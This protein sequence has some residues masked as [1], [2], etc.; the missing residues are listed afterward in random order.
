M[1][2]S[3]AAALSDGVMHNTTVL[4]ENHTLGV[5]D[6]AGSQFFCFEQS[7]IVATDKILTF[8]AF[9][10]LKSE[11]TRH[12]SDLLFRIIAQRKKCS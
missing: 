2:D 8:G 10:R 7:G 1:C 9:S 6:I 12:F 11:R 5:N 3:K 4:S